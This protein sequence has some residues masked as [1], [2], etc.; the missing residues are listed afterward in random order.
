M[1]DEDFRRVSDQIASRTEQK[2]D[3]FLDRY[4]RDQQASRDWRETF[5]KRLEPLEDLNNKL[6]TPLKVFS[7]ILLA[8]FGGIGIAVWKWIAAHWQP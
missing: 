7:A 6:K 2:L 8:F 1:T 5:C 4:E 3:D